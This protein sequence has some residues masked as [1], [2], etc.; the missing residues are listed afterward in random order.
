VPT[1]LQGLLTIGSAITVALLVHHY[2]RRAVPL[3]VL[4]QH[5]EVAATLIALIGGLYGIVLAF[6]VVGSWDDYEKTRA[7]AT[8][9][10]SAVANLYRL[11]SGFPEPTAS[12][13][14]ADM[15]AYFDALVNDE[16]PLLAE[17]KPSPSANRIT[18]NLWDE[19]TRFEPATDGQRNIHLAALSAMQEVSA[20][21]RL[22]VL[23]SARG[24]PEMLWGVIIIGGIVTVGFANF[25]GLR[26]PRSQMIMIGSLAG[27]VALVIFTIFVL[28][29][30]FRGSVRVG[31]DDLIRLREQM[32]K[33]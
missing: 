30:P 4:K 16:W 6:V 20:A 29:H 25:F 12:T 9:E 13:L 21:R 5:N 19:V 18:S 10:A 11:T 15:F 24:I 8:N 27:I 33:Q 3:E 14:R 23:N 26:Y 1:Y 28:D 7:G 22:R 2:V 32:S 17:G 31:P